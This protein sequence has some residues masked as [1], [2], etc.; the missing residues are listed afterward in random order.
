MTGLDRFLDTFVNLAVIAKYWPMVLD[1]L[2]LTIELALAVVAAGLPLGLALALLRALQVR[3]LTWAI[4]AFADILR[5]LPPIVVVVLL[6][7]AL[8]SAGLKLSGYQATWLSLALVLAA[9]A[10]EIFWAGI[11]ATP[12]GQWDAARSTGLGFAQA[13]AW[14]ILPQ[15]LRM[16]IPPLTNRT[17]AVTKGTSLGVVVG[18]QEILTASLTAMD[19]AGNASPLLLGSLAYVLLF[20]PVVSASRWV[21]GRFAWKR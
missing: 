19:F 18:V 16:T 14:V 17:I 10:E 13:L 5:A 6:F 12:K 21:E 4:V 15:A 20:T 11:V 3:P 9:F 2:A 7:F 8:P 1:G